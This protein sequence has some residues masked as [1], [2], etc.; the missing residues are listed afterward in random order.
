LTAK[1]GDAA[2]NAPVLAVVREQVKKKARGMTAP[3]KAVEAV[4]AAVALPFAEGI[5]REAELFRECLF[6]EQSKALI[7]VFFA[8]REAAKIPG[9]TP[10]TP[11]L[12]IRRAAVVGAGTMGGGIAMT[13]ANAGVPVMLKEV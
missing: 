8:E 6:S 3:F 1:L 9:I 11:R 4:E 10:D 7:H 13:Y 5:K 2:S 12:P